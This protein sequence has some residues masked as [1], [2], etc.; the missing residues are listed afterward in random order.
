MRDTGMVSVSLVICT[1]TDSVHPTWLTNT[2]P[3][4]VSGVISMRPFDDVKLGS[5][6]LPWPMIIMTDAQSW[7]GVSEP[8]DM[9]KY[10]ACASYLAR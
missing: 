4:P 9:H 2:I 7:D 10:K 8:C 3:V 1:S 5:C 6:L